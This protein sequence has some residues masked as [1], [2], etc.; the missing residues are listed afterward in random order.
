MPRADQGVVWNYYKPRHTHS[1]NMLVLSWRML[2]SYNF[3]SKV[4]TGFEV[5]YFWE[6]FIL[7]IWLY[8]TTVQTLTKLQS[9]QSEAKKIIKDFDDA[10]LVN[11]RN[12]LKAIRDMIEHFDD[13]AAGIGRGPAIRTTD[14]D[15][16]RTI[17]NDRFERGE[18]ALERSYCYQA[19]VDLKMG[20]KRVSDQFIVWF[21]DNE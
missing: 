17:S 12:G 10:F 14:L 20:A 21:N 1:W 7:R 8:R 3:D 2:D 4:E 19:A 18:F 9:V 11:G 16:W 15:P 13:Y 5:E 6:N